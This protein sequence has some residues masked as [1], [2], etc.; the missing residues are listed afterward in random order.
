MLAYLTLALVSSSAVAVDAPARTDCRSCSFGLLAQAEET[1][2][3]P[4][5]TDGVK[6]PGP[7]LAGWA[8]MGAGVGFATAAVPLGLALASA[9]TSWTSGAF[10]SELLVILAGVSAPV[11]ALIP[12]LGGRSALVLDEDAHAPRLLRILGWV[13]VG[14]GTVGLLT[15]PLWNRAFAALGL[16]SG[17]SVFGAISTVF[18][19]A[20]ASGGIL[21]L[22][23]AARRS[24]TR[25]EEHP[26]ELPSNLAPVMALLP[27]PRGSGLIALAGVRGTL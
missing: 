27:G 11:L 4:L 10:V 2:P 16:G 9:I 6:D 20:L 21:V 5:P 8:R 12:T 13:M 24:A 14:L 25:A 1:P 15:A 23:V 22:S 17:P 3:P 26:P 19:G 7:E 18:E